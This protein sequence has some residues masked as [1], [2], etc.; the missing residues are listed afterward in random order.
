[1]SCTQ[2]P[3]N[4]RIIVSHLGWCVCRV[5][6]CV[7]QSFLLS[8]PN[9]SE[10]ILLAQWSTTLAVLINYMIGKVCMLLC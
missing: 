2:S 1:M 9:E 4:T 3:L 10:N 8:F 5:C 7:G 6:V